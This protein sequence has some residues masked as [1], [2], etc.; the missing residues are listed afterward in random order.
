MIVDENIDLNKVYNNVNNSGMKENPA[1]SV[2]GCLTP[3]YLNSFK[4]SA[5]NQ[6]DFNQKI[7]KSD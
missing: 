1:F 2:R 7:D 3:W 6:K 4:A 5:L